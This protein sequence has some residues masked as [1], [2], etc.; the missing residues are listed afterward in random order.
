MAHDLRTAQRYYDVHGVGQGVRR[1]GAM[2]T[3]MRTR[4]EVRPPSP[5]P[6]D[7]SYSE[8]ESESCPGTPMAMAPTPR[9]MDIP[10]M[11][12]ESRPGTLMAMAPTPPTADHPP[13]TPESRPG[14]PMAMAPT[15][16]TADHP[17]MTPEVAPAAPSS[18]VATERPGR[19]R[20]CWSAKE[21]QLLMRA[22]EGM[23]RSGTYNAAALFADPAVREGLAG[24]TPDQ[25]YNK[26][27]Y[28]RKCFTKM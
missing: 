24:K 21:T 22:S 17:P 20:A 5:G 27:K 3:L 4:G 14:T 15:P 16:P 1:I 6:S 2:A 18:P 25:I 23:V 7:A 9:T 13:M 10:P 28:I 8:S 26:F 19:R 11:T 12:P